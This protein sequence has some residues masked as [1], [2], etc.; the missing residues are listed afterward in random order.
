MVA[1]RSEA[2]FLKRYFLSENLIV[3]RRKSARIPEREPNRRAP[4]PA[5]PAAAYA[6]KP[7]GLSV[8]IPRAAAYA[9]IHQGSP[10]AAYTFRAPRPTKGRRSTQLWP[11]EPLPPPALHQA[12]N[13]Y[14][15]PIPPR[16]SV[17]S[18]T[19]RSAGLRQ[20]ISPPRFGYRQSE[21]Q[22]FS[23]HEQN[24]LSRNPVQHQDDCRRRFSNRQTRRPKPARSF[25]CLFL[26]K[27]RLFVT[28]PLVHAPR[29]MQRTLRAP[30]SVHQ[31]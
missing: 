29:A 28:E 30:A 14:F 21:L 10:A 25:W 2:S 6:F 19:G 3:I 20:S 31:G 17:R 12:A 22:P 26:K 24:D 13:K 27:A 15:S 5:A 16:I 18:L 4:R 9:S 1:S 11:T 8:A 7:T 23:C